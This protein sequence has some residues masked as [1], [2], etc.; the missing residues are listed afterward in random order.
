VL[1][2]LFF[3]FDVVSFSFISISDLS[4]FFIVPFVDK[5]SFLLSLKEEVSFSFLQ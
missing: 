1:Y 4:E 2:F 3:V 5:S